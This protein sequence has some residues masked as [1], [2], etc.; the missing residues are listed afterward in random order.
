M[1]DGYLCLYLL[2]RYIR[3]GRN[4]A[5]ICCSCTLR[6]LKLQEHPSNFCLISLKI[7]DKRKTF[8]DY[9]L[10]I[11]VYSCLLEESVGK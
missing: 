10:F 4:I 5:Q 7:R 1:T 2:L 6:I 3:I 8:F 9:H 11:T